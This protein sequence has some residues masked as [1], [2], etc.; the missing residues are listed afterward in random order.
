MRKRNIQLN[1]LI[2]RVMIL[3]MIASI[4]F[5]SCKKDETGL[6]VITRVRLPDPDKADSTFIQADPGTLIVIQGENL[7]GLLHVYFNNYEASFN[8]VFAT[9]NNIIIRIPADAPT[10]ITDPDVPH[11][12]RV[13]T[14]HGEATYT[15]SLTPPPPDVY[16][17]SNENATPGDEIYMTG[18]YF[19]LIEKIIFPGNVETTEFT[20]NNTADIITLT[21][22]EGAT[23]TGNIKIVTSYHTVEAPMPFND[24]SGEDVV[25]NFDDINTYIWGCQINSDES[26]FPG[27]RGNFA[28]L[29]STNISPGNY[30]WWG[31]NRVCYLDSTQ[32]ITPENLGNLFSEYALKFELYVKEIWNTGQITIVT[33]N[34]WNCRYIFAPWLINGVR[35][36]F[37]TDGWLT[38]IIPLNEF[39]DDEG[40]G[41]PA[42]EFEDIFWDNGIARLGFAYM[43]LTPDPD[44]EEA[45]AI[46]LDNLSIGMDN[47]RIV[48]ISYE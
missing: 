34:D 26:T 22:P 6:P 38:V 36:D 15:F 25:C 2:S 31:N 11:E 17:I 27:A 40:T 16:Y 45:S 43:N 10:E 23:E 24:L 12:I 35:T 1:K 7:G 42:S 48:N 41:D 28:H 4:V 8:S 5:I 46:T 39:K 18:I 47:I 44:N 14:N 37:K 33:Q 19:Y 30:E 29:V 20:V 9:D 3:L 21:V 32:V 13:V